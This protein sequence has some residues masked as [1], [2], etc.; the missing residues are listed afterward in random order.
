MDCGNL[1][2]CC[3]VFP[4]RRSMVF[5]RKHLSD[6][7]ASS[8]LESPVFAPEMLTV[9]DF[10]SNASDAKTTDRVT[11]LIEL[12]ESYKELRPRAESLDDFIFWGDV[13]LGDFNDVDKYLVKADA[14]FANVA[15]FKSI[16]DSYS[17]LTENQRKAIESFILNFRDSQGKL[18]VNI[19][20]ENPKVKERFLQ[21]WN[22]LGKLYH[23]FN[24]R[25]REK[26]MAYEGM[27]YRSLADKLDEIPVADILNRYY[28]GYEKFVFVGLNALNECEKKV[29]RK[30]RDAGL[31]SFCWDY[32]GELISDRSNRSSFFMSE[33]VREFPQEFRPDPDGVRP[34][35]INVISVPS[36][37]GQAKQLPQIFKKTG[38]KSSTDCAIVLPDETMLMTV[39][40]TI[41]PDISEINVTMGY[42]MSAGAFYS[43][44][45]KITS[46]Q[47]HVRKYSAGEGFYHKQ[48]WDLFSDPVFRLA[49]DE[50]TQSIIAEIKAEAKAY[51]LT[52]S[53]EGSEFLKKVFTPAAG[54][55]KTPDKTAIS[56]FSDYLLDVITLVAP[57]LRNLSSGAETGF[58]KE[59]YTAVNR[60]K[61]A[62]LSILPMTYVRLL[63]QLVKGISVPFRGEPIKGLQ[64]MG[65]L[66]MRALDFSNL[67]ILSC[68]ENIFPRRSV[69]SSFIPPELRK[70]FG[71][72]TYE[73]Q[74]AV[75]AYYFYRMITRASEVWMIYDSRTEGM[76]TGEE[77]RYIKQLQYHY[78]DKVEIE[79]FTIETPSLTSQDVMEIPKTSQD[80]QT[81]KDLCFS[82]S[83]LQS[84]ISCPAK[85]YYQYVKKLQASKEVSETLDSSM[86]GQVYHNVMW[87]LYSGEQAMKSNVVTDKVSE[88]QE[89]SSDKPWKITSAYLSS[90]LKRK[91]EIHCKVKELIMAELKEIEITGRNL[92]VAKVITRYVLMT[93]A[94]DIA[95]LKENGVDS[96]TIIGLEKNLFTRFEGFKF[97]GY[98]DRLDSLKKG[99][100]RVVDYKTGYK[101]SDS[102]MLVDESNY[103]KTVNA[104]FDGQGKDS[105]KIVLQFFIYDMLL[106]QNGYAQ[107]IYNSVYST[108]RLAGNP[109]IMYRLNENF[110]EL[111]KEKLRALF[112]Q[113]LDP[114]IQFKRVTDNSVCTMC[115]FRAICGR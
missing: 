97:I 14:V 91:E 49:A 101:I 88:S 79:R 75:W 19:D 55:L 99:Q 31:A 113:M 42:P 45:K 86:F 21:V 36:S 105:P 50:Q 64:I 54:D 48:V 80:I 115:N 73:Y 72:P 26:G 33:N 103:E 9:S 51:V 18:T 34:P 76:K 59:Y 106:R 67:I 15:D 4:N 104:L 35:K 108:V 68:N 3:F 11:L 38:M 37:V 100:I 81:I 71:L 110:Y 28:P 10:F 62:S 82:A 6:A 98:I 41:P 39:L 85:F 24:S 90:W 20:S 102:E 5:F 83:S 93:I 107:E 52:S 92:V 96:F 30:M 32:S 23:N 8:A 12:Y 1:S 70:G 56:K 84:Y 27:V 77:S 57:H 53:F 65:P 112:A 74:D 87:A 60:L 44:M 2:K 114:G 40:N 13:I 61:A 94:R 69:S 47:M 66:E 63:D 109:L 16:Q 43:F 7:M 29:L 78:G 111:M 95:L 46:L 89:N 58:A 25:L 17:Y 22:I